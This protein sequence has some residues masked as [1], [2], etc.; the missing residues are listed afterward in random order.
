MFLIL[1]TDMIQK[2]E[3]KFRILN[4][5]DDTGRKLRIFER[6]L[7]VT[8]QDVFFRELAAEGIQIINTP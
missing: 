6:E 7:S 8:L 2:L 3:D 1:V 5:K 4:R